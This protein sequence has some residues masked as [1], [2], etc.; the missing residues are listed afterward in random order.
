MANQ[1]TER[2]L[3]VAE[4]LASL[5]KTIFNMDD[6]LNMI[7][8]DNAKQFEAL[9]AKV[10]K[11]GDIISLIKWIPFIGAGIS[12]AVTLLFF[13]IKNVRLI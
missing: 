13:L 7:M 11:H 5:T 10:D 2:D 12:G 1:L 3:K 8:N 9:W 4:E 6:K